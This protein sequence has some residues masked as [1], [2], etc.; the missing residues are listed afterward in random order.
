MASA[1]PEDRI[2]LGRL[3]IS[4]RASEQLYRLKAR[5]ALAHV[6]T[7]SSSQSSVLCWDMRSKASGEVRLAD[8][9]VGSRAA[10]PVEEVA[11]LDLVDLFVRFSRD[12][13]TCHQRSVLIRGSTY[14]RCG[15]SASDVA[16]DLTQPRTASDYTRIYAFALRRHQH[17]CLL[18]VDPSSCRRRQNL[19][20]SLT[21]VRRSAG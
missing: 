15:A 19:L 13:A 10:E 8:S 2:S 20:S 12:A 7:R 18:P 1:Q 6:R 3:S 11:D 16:T 4:A 14:P 9:R 21:F 5:H 17:I